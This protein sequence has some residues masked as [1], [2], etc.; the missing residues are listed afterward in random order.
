MKGTIRTF[1]L[2]RRTVSSCLINPG[3]AYLDAGHARLGLVRVVTI[4]ESNKLYISVI[5]MADGSAAPASFVQ[6]Y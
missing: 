4:M 6:P 5:G 2:T 1:V 3:T